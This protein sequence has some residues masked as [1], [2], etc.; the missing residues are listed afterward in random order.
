MASPAIS[1]SKRTNFVAPKCSS[2]DKS[3]LRKWRERERKKEKGTENSETE[4]GIASFHLASTLTS[5]PDEN[6]EEL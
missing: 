4:Y 6:A 2:T 1:T 5:K 3:L